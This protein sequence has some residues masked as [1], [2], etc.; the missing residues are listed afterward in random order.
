MLTSV[1]NP[2]VRQIA[3]LKDKKG[4]EAAGLFLVEGIRFVEE[5]LGA[6]TKVIQVLYSPRLLETERGIR[7]TELAAKHKVP[8]Q[9]VS[10]KVL[11]HAADTDSPQ[12]VVA[13][14]RFPQG[15][16]QSL[17]D[18]NPLLVV[19][20]GVQDPGNL[21]TIIRTAL[22]AG[23]SGVIC[24]KGTAD[25]YN[26]KT[27]RSTMGAIFKIPCVQGVACD[28]LV[29][30]LGEKKIPLLVADARGE[31][32]YYKTRLLTPLAVAIGSEGHGL[33][34]FILKKATWRVRIPLAGGVESLNA[35][36]A[37]AVLL[38]ESARQSAV[39]P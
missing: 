3:S 13:A 9:P 8:L 10:D 33:G 30:W 28:E 4:R 22:A 34:E 27:L 24:T 15:S 39:I 7:L 23:A 12:G 5:A 36:V 1:Q 31:E 21:G 20:D 17:Q 35:A 26:P 25:L 19:V 14:V 16:L 6:G 32:V 11:A 37:A 18:P 2:L 29:D 38:F